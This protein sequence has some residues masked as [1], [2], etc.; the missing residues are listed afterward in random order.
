MGALDTLCCS[1]CRVPTT[2]PSTSHTRSRGLLDAARPFPRLQLPPYHSRSW[3][4][5]KRRR[6]DS[7]APSYNASPPLLSPAPPECARGLK[8][9]TTAVTLSCDPRDRASCTTCGAS[10]GPR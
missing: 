1:C 6:R 10:D 5:A 7:R 3:G 2:Q 9:T 8:K 4:G